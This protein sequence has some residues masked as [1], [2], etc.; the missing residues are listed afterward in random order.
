M[1]RAYNIYLNDILVGYLTEGDNEQ[2]S[3]R[4]AQEYIQLPKRPILGQRFEDNLNK[5]YKGK[6]R[7]DLPDFFSNLIPEEGDLRDLIQKKLNSN[8][9]LSVLEAVGLDLPGAIIIK[10][11]DTNGIDFSE[12]DEE[13][14]TFATEGNGDQLTFR[15]SLAGIQLKFSVSREQDRLT[16]PVSGLGG[17]WIVKFDSKRFPNLVE[18]EFVMMDWA[19]ASGFNVPECYLQ[20][21]ENLSLELQKYNQEE[22]N[23]FVIRRYDRI[24]GNRIH[25]EDF[26]QVVGLASKRKYD[27]VS[28]E[29]IGILVANIIGENGYYNYIKRLTFMIASGNTDLHLKNWSLVY[30][31][32]INAQLSPLYDQVS[33]VA[34]N[35]RELALRFSKRSYIRQVDENCFESLAEKSKMDVTKTIKTMQE[36]LKNIHSSWENLEAK[37]FLPLNHLQSLQEYWSSA[38]LLKNYSLD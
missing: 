9:D 17:E 38:P 28:Y 19:R 3:F 1:N 10:R 35:L 7:G 37:R 30:P 27:H 21:N 26:A 24:N 31:D 22:N 18:N 16:L 33:T 11:S 6:R 36:C 25:Q 29:Q 5:V 13:I 2:I 23:I 20:T 14:P 4:L 12:D 32:G 8:D 34:W 15:F